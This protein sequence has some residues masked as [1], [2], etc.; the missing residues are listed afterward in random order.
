MDM[1]LQKMD[2]S[3]TEFVNNLKE[4]ESYCRRKLEE[5]NTHLSSRIS[6]P[7]RKEEIT[8]IAEYAMVCYDQAAQM[9][10]SQQSSLSEFM[11]KR[12]EFD[13]DRKQLTKDE[14]FYIKQNVKAYHEIKRA[15]P[16]FI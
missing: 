16:D 4:R 7:D 2:K 1:D 8:K 9:M 6:N 5:C 11:Q 10:R 3:I 12:I 13:I 14:V 15:I